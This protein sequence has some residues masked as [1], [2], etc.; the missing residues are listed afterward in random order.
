MFAVVGY[1]TPRGEDRTAGV[2]Y[3]V[4]EHRLYFNTDAEAWKTRHLRENP[5]ISVTVPAARRVPFLPWIRVPPATIAFHGTARII[6]I[7][8]APPG[9]VDSLVEKLEPRQELLR[10]TSVVEI[11]PKGHFVTYGIG[12]PVRTMLRPHEAAGRVPVE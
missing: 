1:V 2:V 8:D 9:I 11:T 12:V 4:R 10:G 3:R 7:E 6:A 5:S